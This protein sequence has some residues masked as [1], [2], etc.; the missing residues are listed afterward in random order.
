MRKLFTLCFVLRPGEILLG[1]KKRGFGA[2]RWNG[3]GG[4]LSPG[5]SIEEATIR[6]TREE[7]G[8]IVHD[9]IPVGTHEFEFLSDPGTILEVHV[10]R[11]Q[12]YSG[13]IIETEEMEPRWFRFQDIPYA[14][15]WPDDIHWLPLLLEGKK[16]ET[17]F[18]FGAGDTLLEWSVEEKDDLIRK[19]T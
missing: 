7:S 6:E 3:F 17:R 8:V 14:E 1:L 12:D 2:G 13:E 15:M 11:C 5:E 16:F 9:L 4:K 10:F 19:T 18:L